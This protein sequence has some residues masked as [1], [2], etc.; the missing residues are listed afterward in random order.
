MKFC[1][2]QC[3]SVFFFYIGQVFMQYMF[4]ELSFFFGNIFLFSVNVNQ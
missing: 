3:N 4:N 1:P 2:S